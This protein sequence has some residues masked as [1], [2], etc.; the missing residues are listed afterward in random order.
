MS[1]LDLDD[2][3]TVKRASATLSERLQEDAP[4]PYLELLAECEHSR[5]SIEKLLDGWVPGVERNDDKKEHPNLVPWE[6]EGAELE[7]LFEGYQELTDSDKQKDRNN[8]EK[9][10]EL[11]EGLIE[12]L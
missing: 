2:S 9:I 11:L 8:I 7:E 10:P 5:W 1:Y 3:E 12:E 6:I 4:Q